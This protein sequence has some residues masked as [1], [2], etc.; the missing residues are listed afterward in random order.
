MSSA[1]K[2]ADGKWVAT[3]TDGRH[4]PPQKTKR[5]A[6]EW[7]QGQ[8][9]DAALGDQFSRLMS[10]AIVKGLTEKKNGTAYFGST[11]SYAYHYEQ[12]VGFGY[13]TEHER[14]TA[15]GL[16][17]YERCLARLSQKRQINW[18]MEGGVGLADLSITN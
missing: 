3:F 10:A 7:I 6:L 17:W 1:E 13:V 16:E 11:G 15:R 2:Q 5:A 18:N 9:V 12:A 8:L 4:S 14:V